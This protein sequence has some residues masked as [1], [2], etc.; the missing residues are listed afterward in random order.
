VTEGVRGSGGPL[1]FGLHGYRIMPSFRYMP[2]EQRLELIEF[3][4]SLNRAFW[5][6]RDIKTVA[7]RQCHRG[8]RSAGEWATTLHGC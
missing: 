3:V 8:R 4:K 5:E 2:E 6:Q 7:I 1:T